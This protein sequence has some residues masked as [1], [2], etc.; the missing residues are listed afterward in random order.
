M[1]NEKEIRIRDLIRISTISFAIIL[2]VDITSI[3]VLGGITS[4]DG[5][6]VDLCMLAV[7]VMTVYLLISNMKISKEDVMKLW[8]DFTK[9]VNIKEIIGRLLNLQ[10]IQMGVMWLVIG[11]FLLIDISLANKILNSSSSQEMLYTGNILINSISIVIIAPI[12]EELIYRK[13]IFKRL[14]KKLNTTFGTILSSI[15]FGLCHAK[16]SIFF[17]TLFGVVLCILYLK[18]KNILVPM[19]LHFLNNFMTTII[20]LTSVGEEN[21]EVTN[22]IPEDAVVFLSIGAIATVIGVFFYIRFIKRNR[23]YLKNLKIIA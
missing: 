19:F 18:Y 9:K 4:W 13:V 2:G 5:F 21:N 3:L 7:E 1:V 15:F 23:S 17:A 22:F 16:D 12:I 6:N 14:S 10:I 20:L 8:V 11:I